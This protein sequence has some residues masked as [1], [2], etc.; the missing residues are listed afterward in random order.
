VKYPPYLD[1]AN[2]IGTIADGESHDT[3]TV[4][5]EPDDQCLLKRRYSAADN[6]F[7]LDGEGQEKVAIAFVRER[8]MTEGQNIN[9]PVR[10]VGIEALT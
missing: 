6:A 1:H 9:P 7:A 3:Q 2:V 8:L 10:S 4:L 5:D